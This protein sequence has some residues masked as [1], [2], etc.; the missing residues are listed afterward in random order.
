LALRAQTVPLH[1]PENIGNT[2]AIMIGRTH[3]KPEGKR[4]LGRP[5]RR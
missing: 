2:G 4:I 3:G 5:R 1:K